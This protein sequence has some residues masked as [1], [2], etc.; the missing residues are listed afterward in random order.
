MFDID[1]FNS[2]ASPR[3]HPAYAN[4]TQ[5]QFLNEGAFRN[6]YLVVDSLS[7]SCFWSHDASAQVNEEISS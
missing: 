4:Q 5:D 6:G 2:D 7:F 3:T 1:S